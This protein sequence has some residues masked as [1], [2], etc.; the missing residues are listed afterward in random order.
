MVLQN[1]R[2]DD[3][4]SKCDPLLCD[5]CSFKSHLFSFADLNILLEPSKKNELEAPALLPA[6][7]A[8]AV[9]ALA[10]I[11]EAIIA[12]AGAALPLRDVAARRTRAVI[13]V[14]AQRRGLVG[15]VD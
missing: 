14:D 4:N 9:Q 8:F 2:F 13:V 15:F 5:D 10:V 3:H 7:A 11:A 12:G 6:L 1:M